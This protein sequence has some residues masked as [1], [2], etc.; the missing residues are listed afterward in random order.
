[1]LRRSLAA[2]LFASLAAFAVALPESQQAL[3]N[4][5]TAPDSWEYKDCGEDSDAVQIKS[6]TVSPDPPKIGSDL[7]VTIVADVK[8]TIEEGATADVLVKVGRIKLLEQSFDLCE[9]A[10][11]ANASIS[12]PVEPGLHTIEQTVTLPKEVPKLKYVISVRGF[13]VEEDNMACVDLTVQFRPFFQF[14]E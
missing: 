13:T 10:R 5:R 6:I 9:E 8:E 12:C 14:W 1:M 2:L 7:T 4:V 3:G 11:K